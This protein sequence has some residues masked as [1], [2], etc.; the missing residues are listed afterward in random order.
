MIEK[1]LV[2][3]L[4]K[5]RPVKLIFFF[6]DICVLRKIGNGWRKANRSQTIV[7]TDVP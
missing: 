6:I 1:T 4:S 3:K 7:V 5:K 2:R